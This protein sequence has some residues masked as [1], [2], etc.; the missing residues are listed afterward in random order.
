MNLNRRVTVDFGV[1]MKALMLMGL[2][3]M[4]SGAA[5]AEDLRSPRKPHD[6]YQTVTYTADITEADIDPK[7]NWHH[8]MNSG[9]VDVDFRKGVVRLTVYAKS[10]C[11][12]NRI[13][14]MMMPAPYIVELPIVSVKRNGC[15][16][17][18]TTAKR[19]KRPVDGS[20]QQLTVVD[21]SQLICRY[22]PRAATIV[23]YITDSPRTINGHVST[24]SEFLA[25][26]LSKM[27]N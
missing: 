14:A 19:D 18:V 22:L 25:G 27:V 10:P 3:S 1:F 17:L 23:E 13:C 12:P 15:G 9:T 5:S 11:P 16:E 4:I 20:L 24:K 7:L 2:V 6:L 21:H 26:P 8:A